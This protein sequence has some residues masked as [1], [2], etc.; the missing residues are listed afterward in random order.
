M[1]RNITNVFLKLIDLIVSVN[2]YVEIR[3]YLKIKRY[4]V[5]KFT[6]ISATIID[7]FEITGM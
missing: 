4:Y 2:D 6:F 7:G 1:G 5:N 3:R